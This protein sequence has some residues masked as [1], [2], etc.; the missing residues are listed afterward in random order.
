LARSEEWGV[1]L[2]VRESG[3]RAQLRLRSRGAGRLAT[4]LFFPSMLVSLEPDLLLLPS[5]SEL[6][7][8]PGV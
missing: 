6:F 7:D 1:P 3:N 2:V 4:R 5:R 8:T